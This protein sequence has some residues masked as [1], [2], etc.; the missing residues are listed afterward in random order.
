MRNSTVM[1]L[2]SSSAFW[3]PFC[4]IVQKSAGLFEINASLILPSLETLTVPEV[5]AFE[6][7]LQ[8]GSSAVSPHKRTQENARMRILSVRKRSR[9]ESQRDRRID[10]VALDMK[11]CD[12]RRE[13]RD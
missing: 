9:P 6:S 3:V 7:R 12:F 1:S 13:A 5:G 10:P 8:A 11:I 4:A 2:K